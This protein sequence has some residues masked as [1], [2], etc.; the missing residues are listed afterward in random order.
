MKK[1]QFEISVYPNYPLGDAK[2]GPTSSAMDYVKMDLALRTQLNLF[3]NQA[4]KSTSWPF[5]LT[6]A[7][8]QDEIYITEYDVD[9]TGTHLGHY[10][11][12][13]DIS[14]GF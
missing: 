1:T 9:G 7:F 4:E 8:S 13:Y 11:G 10:F 12:T 6:F 3:E 5:F 2:S 14:L